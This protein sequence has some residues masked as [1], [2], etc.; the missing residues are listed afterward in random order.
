MD[1]LGHSH[2]G[3][4][5]WGGIGDRFHGDPVDNQFLRKPAAQ[6]DHVERPRQVQFHNPLREAAVGGKIG[7]LDR[8]TALEALAA[9]FEVGREMFAVFQAQPNGEPA[10]SRRDPDLI[11]HADEPGLAGKADSLATARLRIR[12]DLALV[13]TG[14]SGEHGLVPHVFV[15]RG[16]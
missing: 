3:H 4:F 2:G 1:E 11:V 9:G 8:G 12:D 16:G 15:R 14:T 7:E 6:R 13:G 10:P 5:H